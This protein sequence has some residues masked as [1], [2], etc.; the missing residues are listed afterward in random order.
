MI[1]EVDATERDGCGKC[2]GEEGEEGALKEVERS[3]A[4][5]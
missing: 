4:V 3:V 2:E 1:V 5:G